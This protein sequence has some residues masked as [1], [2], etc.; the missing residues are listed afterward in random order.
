MHVQAG[1]DVD[2][3]PVEKLPELTRPM[4]LMELPHDAARCDFHG[5][6]GRGRA[7][8]SIVMRATLNLSRAHEQ[9]QTRTVQGLNLYR[10]IDA[11]GQRF[12]RRMEIQTDTIAHLFD[13]QEIGRQL[14][15]LG[16]VRLQAKGEPDVLHGAATH[17]APLRQRLNGLRSAYPL[18]KRLSF[19]HRQ[20][21][22]GRRSSRL[23][24][25]LLPI[26]EN[27]SGARLIP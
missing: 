3:D 13:K 9:Q 24:G 22:R 19:G 17:L 2:L 1:R 10:F 7:M 15:C 11:Q 4:P 21:Q 5:G 20:G 6:E 8:A 27:T 18:L 25:V 14:E 16:P 12:I 23:H 26:P